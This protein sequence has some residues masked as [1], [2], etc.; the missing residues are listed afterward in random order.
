MMLNLE[1]VLESEINMIQ[2]W[3]T[4]WKKYQELVSLLLYLWFVSS[5]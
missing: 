2:L 5:K 3:R 1:E 4:S